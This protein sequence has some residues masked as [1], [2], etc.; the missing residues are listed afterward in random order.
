[1]LVD[2]L[3]AQLLFYQMDGANHFIQEWH[4]YDY[5]INK[6]V[7]LTTPQKQF[8]GTMMGINER[9]ELVLREENGESKT[10]SYGEVSCRV[11]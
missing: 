2:E 4:Q 7:I 10:F 5:L 1:M 11:I 8:F 9:G 6:S 3:L